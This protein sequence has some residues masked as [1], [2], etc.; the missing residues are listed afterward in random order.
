MKTAEWALSGSRTRTAV[1]TAA[2]TMSQGSW[3]LHC[4]LR[5]RTQ[6]RQDQNAHCLEHV[7]DSRCCEGRC[8]NMFRTFLIAVKAAVWTCSGHFSLLWR[9]LFEHIQDFLMAVKAAVW[10]CSGLFSLL[11]RGL[12][13]MFR[14]LPGREN[15]FLNIFETLTAV[16]TAYCACSELRVLT[17]TKDKYS[18]MFGVRKAHCDED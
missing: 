3:V 13:V 1:K 5:L 11:W 4:P 7:Q 12:L 18:N 10:T 2:G 6:H 14:T 8:L 15:C 9:P 17:A 16:K